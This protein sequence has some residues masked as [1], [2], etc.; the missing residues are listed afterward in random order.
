MQLQRSRKAT[1]PGNM[2]SA[3]SQ[4]SL[5]KVIGGVTLWHPSGWKLK[6]VLWFSMGLIHRNAYWY[7]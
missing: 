5:T 6:A 4:F 7:L 1:N 2:Y 3:S